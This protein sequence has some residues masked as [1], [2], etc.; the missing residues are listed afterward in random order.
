MVKSN[1]VV[2]SVVGGVAPEELED[3][4]VAENLGAPCW[5]YTPYPKTWD[6]LESALKYF[7]CVFRPESMD[8][9][10]NFAVRCNPHDDR[11]GFFSFAILPCSDMEDD[12]KRNFGVK[13]G[14]VFIN[15]DIADVLNVINDLMCKEDGLRVDTFITDDCS[16]MIET[17]RPLELLQMLGNVLTK[18]SIS[19]LDDALDLSIGN[20]SHNDPEVFFQSRYETLK[21]N[22]EE[23]SELL[24][25]AQP[26][27]YLNIRDVY[28]SAFMTKETTSIPFSMY[29]FE[30]AIRIEM[31]EPA[32]H[33]MTRNIDLGYLAIN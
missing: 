25:Y 26:R 22:P 21:D 15:D 1:F 32:P 24:S 20:F 28:N 11:P 30:E 12:S 2:S 33:R 5:Y 31:N 8:Q 3:R 27:T 14:E 17:T 16:L 7:F 9:N 19:I 23:E 4:D 6:A 10:D 29:L 18:H 13:D